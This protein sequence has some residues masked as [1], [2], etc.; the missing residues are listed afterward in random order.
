MGETIYRWG[1]KGKT[2]SKSMRQ[3][4]TSSNNNYNNTNVKVNNNNENHNDDNT[5]TTTLLLLLPLLLLL[6]LLIIIIIIIY[7]NNN[8]N[9]GIQ[10]RHIYKEALH[11]MFFRSNFLEKSS[12]N[13][14]SMWHHVKGYKEDMKG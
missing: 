10:Q 4:S 6:L 14:S 9:T 13:L 5:T 3:L 8:D 12:T 7:S 11:S 1:S 2:Y